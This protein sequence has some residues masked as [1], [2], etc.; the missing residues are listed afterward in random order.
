MSSH[1]IYK[2][3]Q[4]RMKEK[5]FIFIFLIIFLLTLS[6]NNILTPRIFAQNNDSPPQ[7]VT[8]TVLVELF[9]QESCLSCPISEFCLEDLAWEYGTLKFILVEEHLWGDTPETNARYDWYVGDGKRGI[10][11]VFIDGL[12]KRFQGLFCD[13]I[14]GNYECYKDAID[15]ELTQPSLLELTADK[16]PLPDPIVQGERVEKRAVNI[17]IEGTVKN[18]SHVPLKDLAVCGMLG[19]EGDEPGLYFYI[20][21]IF[22]LQNMSP[23]LPGATFNFK[24]IPEISLEQESEVD[25]EE[26]ILHFVIFVQ[27]TITKEVLQALY[28]E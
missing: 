14:E 8:R 13:C 5:I 1:R 27:N 4:A 22:P 21:D 11:D 7:T 9:V 19:K 10:P 18:T 15:E 28:I 25:A 24:F 12:T 26:E 20:Q 23:L 3:K 16:I 17:I 6:G 2:R